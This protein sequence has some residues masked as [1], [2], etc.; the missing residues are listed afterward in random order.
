MDFPQRLLELLPEDKRQ[1]L[2]ELLAQDPRPA[3]QKDPERV[4]GM[5]F[6]GFEIKF[7]VREGLLTVLQAKKL[8]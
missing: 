4:Y 5:E 2:W 7:S 6:S 8:I 1:G 3:Y